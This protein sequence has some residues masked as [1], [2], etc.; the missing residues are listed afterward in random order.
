MYNFSSKGK[1]KESPNKRK[2]NK[3]ILVIILQ[4]DGEEKVHQN[5][6]IF[7]DAVFLCSAML[8]KGKETSLV[9]NK[10]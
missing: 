4:D 7:I 5:V 10:R 1:S 2:T 8:L 3:K 6:I 9:N